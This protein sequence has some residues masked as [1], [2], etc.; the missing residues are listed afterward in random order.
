MILQESKETEN[1]EGNSVVFSKTNSTLMK[2][3]IALCIFV[4]KAVTGHGIV[5]TLMNPPS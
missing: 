1:G 4:F 5:D 3:D 2:F